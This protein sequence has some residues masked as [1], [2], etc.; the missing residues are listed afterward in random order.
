MVTG[1]TTTTTT[2]E[3]MLSLQPTSP[4]LDSYS[5]AMSEL[6]FHLE[7]PAVQATPVFSSLSCLFCN[8]PSDS[9]EENL[10]HMQKRHGLFI[11]DKEHLI[12]DLESL[13][14]Y[15]HLVIFEYKE[16]LYCHTSRRTIQAV[17][18][19]M[20][21]TGHC[22]FD[23]SD[24]DSEFRDFYEYD[25]PEASFSEENQ[26]NNQVQL[27]SRGT[28]TSPVQVDDTS[29]RLPS[30]RIVSN[31][32][33]PAPRH[34]SRKPLEPQPP[35]HASTI[36]VAPAVASHSDASESSRASEDPTLPK[37]LPSSK[38]LAKQERQK[39]ALAVQLSSMR[40]SDQRA[41]AHLPA[42]EQRAVLSQA[43]RL[44]AQSD[45]ANRQFRGQMDS[46][47][48]VLMKARFVNDVPGASRAHKNRFFAA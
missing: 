47:G 20:M 14:E 41:L 31:R 24:E 37:D 40:S 2:N 43:L 34:P 15:L 30:G 32:S 5:Y 16:C 38:A 12:L 28:S 29:M 46:L 17:Q 23:I 9:L 4:Q 42:S 25:E 33:A 11:P 44:E 35:R 3:Q 36:S 22:K 27:W 48:N 18:Q 13:L 8:S 6:P 39:A 10:E 1:I 19:H 45:R 7:T 21:G 26:E